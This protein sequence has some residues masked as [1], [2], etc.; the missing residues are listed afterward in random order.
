M[1][2]GIVTIQLN[3]TMED[4]PRDSLRKLSSLTQTVLQLIHFN[5][6]H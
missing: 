1:N 6:A 4:I 2:F 3:E 5:C